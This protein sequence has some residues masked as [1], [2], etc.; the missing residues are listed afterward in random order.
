MPYVDQSIWSSLSSRLVRDASRAVTRR[1]CMAG[2]M[3]TCTT[4][5]HACNVQFAWIIFRINILYNAKGLKEEACLAGN[6]WFG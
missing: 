1:A 4:Y 2:S 6:C 5:D 3:M